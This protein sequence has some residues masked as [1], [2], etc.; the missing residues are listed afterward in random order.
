MFLMILIVLSI[1]I[2]AEINTSLVNAYFTCDY[3]DVNISNN[4]DF[5]NLIDNADAVNTTITLVNG[6]V[7]DACDMNDD[8]DKLAMP[9]NIRYLTNTDFMSGMGFSFWINTN[10]SGQSREEIL[11]FKGSAFGLVEGNDSSLGLEVFDSDGFTKTIDILVTDLSLEDNW[12]HVTVTSFNDSFGFTNWTIYLNGVWVASDKSNNGIYQSGSGVTLSVGNWNGYIDEFM[13]INQTLSEQDA[14]LLYLL[15]DTIFNYDFYEF[16]KYGLQSYHDFDDSS[17]QG[18]ITLDSSNP[19]LRNGTTQFSTTFGANGLIKQALSFDGIDDAV[20]FANDYD[21]V[22]AIEFWFKNQSSVGAVLYWND[23]ADERFL[24]ELR[25]IDIFRVTIDDG[26]ITNRDKNFSSWGLDSSGDVYNHI[27]LNDDGTDGTDVWINGLWRDNLPNTLPDFNK[28]TARGQICFFSG[29]CTSAFLKGSIDEM[30]IYNRSLLDSEIIKFYNDT[31]GFNPLAVD[32]TAPKIRDVQLRIDTNTTDLINNSIINYYNAT[33]EFLFD[34]TDNENDTLFYTINISNSTYQFFYAYNQSHV[35]LSE[36]YFVDFNDNPFKVYIYAEDSEGLFN[37][38]ELYFN[39]SDWITP[40]C[41]PLVDSE[42]QINTTFAWDVDCY[43][44]NFFSF[45]LSCS[46]GFLFNETN[47]NLPYYNFINSSFIWENTTC[48]YEYCDG[49]T[50][51]KLDF[52]WDI[53]K[54]KENGKDVAEIRINNKKSQKL[55]LRENA[56]MTFYETY[57]R[58]NFDINFS[59]QSSFYTLYYQTSPDSYYIPSDE[60]K[61]WIV[62]Y[63]QRTWFDLN[64]GDDET[65]VYVDRLNDTTWEIEIHNPDKTSYH[66]SSIGELNCDSGTQFIE[67]VLPPIPPEPSLLPFE[68]FLEDACPLNQPLSYIV[69]Y[70]GLIMLLFVILF[71]NEMFWKIP[72]FNF[73]IGISFVIITIPI[74]DCNALIGTLFSLFGLILFVSEFYRLG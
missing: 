49:H 11:T 8:S 56:E 4:Q 45:Y 23:Q 14:K 73:L 36:L 17:K 37:S 72:V 35:N 44:E 61:G 69:G 64:D 57:D 29:D 38:T 53:L 25:A 55:K 71:I 34:I 6:K 10:M 52:K 30:A 60:Y 40:I 51:D 19:P 27:V 59:S 16:L 74:Y 48:S 26:P 46:N 31:A 65:V 21:T 32:G 2:Y 12:N 5:L 47:I 68:D 58:V 54:K 63:E 33:F 3:K 22:K 66:F 28:G 39:M 13:I 15:N 7:R 70:M 20:N 41:S 1:S 42:T 67:A 9:T 62:D 18:T 43:D 50:K 24:I